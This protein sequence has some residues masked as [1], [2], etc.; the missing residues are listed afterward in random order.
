MSAWINFLCHGD[1]F[2]GGGELGKEE[3]EVCEETKFFTAKLHVLCTIVEVEIVIL[4]NTQLW[5]WK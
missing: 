4:Q 5:A 1:F 3:R 2:L